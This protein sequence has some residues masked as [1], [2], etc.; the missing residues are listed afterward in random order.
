MSMTTG[1]SLFGL[2]FPDACPDMSSTACDRS[3]LTSMVMLTSPSAFG[4]G[5][6]MGLGTCMG[7]E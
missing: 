3:S 4:R 7:E 2:E 1:F 5:A 6:L